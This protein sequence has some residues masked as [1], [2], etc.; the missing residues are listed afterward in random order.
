MAS[1]FTQNK[2][3]ELP[4]N[5]DDVGTWDIP[6]NADF[7]AIDACFGGL[8]TLNVTAVSGT[9][10]LTFTQCRP[11]IIELTGTLTG[12]LI[13]AFPAN[14][15]GFW[16]VKN[17]TTGAFTVTFSSLTGGGS[18]LVVAQGVTTPIMC[19]KTNVLL[20]STT[21]PPAAGVSTEIQYNSGGVLA[22][23]G[24]LT[25]DGS[26]IAIAGSIAAGGTL[27]LT[28]N[29]LTELNI[30]ASAQTPE[31][32]V[33]FSATAMVVNCSLSNVFFGVLLANVTVAPTIQNAH[34]GQTINWFIAQDAT[35]G[36]TMTWPGAFRWPNGAP[37]V[38]STGASAIDLL[39]ATYLSSTG[40]WYASLTKSFA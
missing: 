22:G 13:Y 35:G 1:S 4:A 5:G 40:V 21:P 28:G 19:D 8:T 17:G 33:S 11:P 34:D 26:S 25:T 20:Q 9:T 30:V 7:T 12:N 27:T 29:V 6:N 23:S 24:N 36:R 39:V 38:L 2:N 3:L 15:G 37:G 31:S 14:A 10:N 32:S 18:T 16:F